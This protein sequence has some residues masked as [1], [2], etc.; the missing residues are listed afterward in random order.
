MKN[1]SYK[2]TVKPALFGKHNHLYFICIYKSKTNKIKSRLQGCFN[3]LEEVDQNL[4]KKEI[5]LLVKLI[6]S[7]NSVYIK[8]IVESRIF[9][10]EVEKV[11][12]DSLVFKFN[13]SRICLYIRMKADELE[14]F[15]KAL[16]SDKDALI[17]KDVDELRSFADYLDPKNFEERR[18][19]NG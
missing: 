11:D 1:K 8:G 10:N 12:K 17:N 9:R 18:Q 15:Q 19:N 7:N 13:I 14:I 6:K 16:G 3:S 2:L 5:D 4:L